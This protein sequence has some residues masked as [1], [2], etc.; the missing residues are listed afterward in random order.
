LTLFTFS[1][2]CEHDEYRCADGTCIANEFLCDA[3]MD[4]H[5]NADEEPCVEGKMLVVLECLIKGQI[6]AECRMQIC[7]PQHTI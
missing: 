2:Q 5:D 4:C 6:N 1:G 3:I 7:F